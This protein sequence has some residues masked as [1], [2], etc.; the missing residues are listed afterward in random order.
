LLD[1]CPCA[2]N[3]YANISVTQDCDNA[4]LYN[5]NIQITDLGSGSSFADIYNNG[6]IAISNIG[7]GTHN[8]SDLSGSSSITIINENECTSTQSFNICDPCN[9][10]N[11][12]ADEACN[13][14][15]VDLSEPYY[16]SSNCGYTVNTSGIYDGPDGLRSSCNRDDGTGS[17]GSQNDSWLQFTAADDSVILDWEVSNCTDGNGVQFAL[18]DGSC[19]DE[20]GMVMLDCEYQ[21]IGNGTFDIGNLTIGTNYF[22]YIDGFLADECDYSWTP[23]GGVAIT[24]PNDTCGNATLIACGDLD[25]S[26]NIL[27]SNIDAPASCNGLTPNV[28]VWYKY[29]GN[30]TDVTLSTD[31]I[32][33]NFD[34]QIFLYSGDCQNLVCIDSDDDSGATSGTS[35]IE[36]E[37]EDGTDYYIYVGGDDSSSTPIGQ[38]G[39]SILCTSCEADAGNWD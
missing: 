28:G 10:S 39:L 33:T 38:F 29:V 11:A 8:L 14:P 22:L 20:D 34:T 25:T 17:F 23:Q 13:A 18:L 1:G 16:G 36:F 35:Q 7:V 3:E 37:A 30:G 9:S 15:L 31:N 5:L 4:P 6:S 2:T 32:T 24:P 26:N 12:P 27:A 19:N 21:A